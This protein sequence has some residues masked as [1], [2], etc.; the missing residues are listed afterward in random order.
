MGKPLTL[1]DIISLSSWLKEV[2]SIFDGTVFL[3]IMSE[4]GHEILDN[5]LKL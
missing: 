3:S 4:Y 5:F 2:I 1:I